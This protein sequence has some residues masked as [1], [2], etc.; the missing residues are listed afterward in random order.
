MFEG[1]LLSIL[2]KRGVVLVNRKIVTVAA[3]LI[4]ASAVLTALPLRATEVSNKELMQPQVPGARTVTF[5]WYDFFQP[6]AGL[7]KD[8][9]WTSE[10]YYG[11]EHALSWTFPQVIMAEDSRYVAAPWADS[12]LNKPYGSI[13]WARG[14]A[15]FSSNARLKVV[16]NNLPEINMTKG[17]SWDE[18]GTYM[19]GV[20]EFL[21]YNLLGSAPTGIEPGNAEIHWF[22]TYINLTEFGSGAQG[23]QGKGYYDGWNYAIEGIVE[24]QTQPFWPSLVST[25]VL[26]KNAAMRVLGITEATWNTLIADP[27]AWWKSNQR[28]AEGGWENWIRYEANS[29]LDIYPFYGG[30]YFEDFMPYLTL[31]PSYNAATQKLTFT[32]DYQAMGMECLLGRWFHE[33]FLPY[34]GYAYPDLHLDTYIGPTSANL[35]LDTGF[36]WC[37]DMVSSKYTPN[38]PISAWA[39]ETR[40]GDYVPSEPPAHPYS[41]YDPYVGKQWR[42]LFV[43]PGNIKYGGPYGEDYQFLGNTWDLKEG[44]KLV[45]NY[46]TPSYVWALAKKPGNVSQIIY[47]PDAYYGLDPGILVYGPFKN[48]TGYLSPGH[49]EPYPEDFPGQIVIDKIGKAVSF[50]GPIDMEEW[51]KWRLADKWAALE[52][53]LPW[54]CP[55]IEFNVVMPGDLDVDGYVGPIDLNIFAAA[56]GKRRGD[57]LYNPD[58]DLNPFPA[59]DGYIGPVDLNLFAASYGKRTT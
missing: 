38:S 56:Y 10:S 1:I 20:G 58:A 40:K 28:L 49:I 25:V 23:R 14:W 51:S 52:G 53:L 18:T 19:L 33:T 47:D 54:G 39:F 17:N 42:D 22:A 4:L 29:R 34:E 59:A 55:Y 41:E 48:Y 35:T 3:L 7:C 26:D 37:L 21:P 45:F 27:A 46:S 11:D 50:I 16:A 2:Q 9:W 12:P 8:A 15:W 44:E 13:A 36:T 30:W 5:T 57:L 6:S 32:F 24:Y 43:R 31:I